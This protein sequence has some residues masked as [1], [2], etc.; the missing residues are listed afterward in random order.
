M[1]RMVLALLGISIGLLASG[2]GGGGDDS[3]PPVPVVTTFPIFQSVVNVLNRSETRS[4]SVSGTVSGVTIGGSG[5]ATFGSLGGA[6]FEGKSA[7]AKTT[8]V[9]G[10][11]TSGT[12]SAPYG[13][14][15]TLYVDTNYQPLGSTSATLYAVVFGPVTIPQTASVNSTGRL[16][17]ANR[18]TNSTKT[19]KLGTATV[20]FSLQQ[21][22]PSTAVLKLITTNKS[23]TGALE[24]T[25]IENYRLT[26]SADVTRLSEQVIGGADS[27]TFTYGQ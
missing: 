14:T 16:Y 7:L 8:V 19:V 22:T 4:F 13:G 26:A 24:G 15:S 23:T 10:T 18:Y 27:L 21:E 11:L 6:T 2:C 25:V 9:T 12:Q 20:E 3:P 5:T 17:E 1:R